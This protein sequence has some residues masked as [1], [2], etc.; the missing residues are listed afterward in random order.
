MK[1]I[2]S[3]L[4]GGLAL[5]AVK[6]A[7]EV[8]PNREDHEFEQ[9]FFA[10]RQELIDRNRDAWLRLSPPYPF[11]RKIAPFL[12]RRP[13]AFCI[14]S[15]RNEASIR[16]L[17][18]LYLDGP[19]P[20]VVG[21]E[22]VAA[23]GGEKAHVIRRRLASGRTG[24]FVDDC[25]AHLEMARGIDGLDLMEAGWGYVEPDALND[26]AAAVEAVVMDILGR[27]D[28]VSE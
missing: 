15:T 18:A 14:L 4:R 27:N 5:R 10:C 24:L 13:E 12:V 16:E 2:E 9:R 20:E 25:R 6:H 7:V 19:F 8:P 21:A 1:G 23:A 17:L 22:A 11:F 26:N 28:G 3:G